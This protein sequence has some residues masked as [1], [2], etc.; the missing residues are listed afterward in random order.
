MNIFSVEYC[1]KLYMYLYQFIFYLFTLHLNGKCSW[2]VL[3]VD[4]E[5]E[6]WEIVKKKEEKKTMRE[7]IGELNF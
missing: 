5:K 6:Q 2:H 1:K 7:R 4:E 3:Q